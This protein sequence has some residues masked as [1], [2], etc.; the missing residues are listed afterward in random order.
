MSLSGDLKEM[1]D[2]ETGERL[3]NTRWSDIDWVC[4]E[5][6]RRVFHLKKSW[7]P[8]RPFANVSD[9]GQMHIANCLNSSTQLPGFVMVL[10][11]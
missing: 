4:L 8:K 9:K 10:P 6:R 5:S 2:K 3:R 11:G 7:Y 1:E